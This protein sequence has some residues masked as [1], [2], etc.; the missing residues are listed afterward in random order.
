MT[1]SPPRTERKGPLLFL[2]VAAL[3]LWGYN[4]SLVARGLS[5]SDDDEVVAPPAPVHQ[6]SS[7][8]L[9]G[10]GYP[11]PF[12]PLAFSSPDHTVTW[13]PT[14]S[15][16]DVSPGSTTS[17]TDTTPQ[18]SPATPSYEPSFDWQPEPY[19][20]PPPPLA[21]RGVVGRRALIADME[22]TVHLL[23]PGDTLAGA[24]LQRV[25]DGEAHLT[26]GGSPFTLSL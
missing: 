7:R 1:V 2:T 9:F 19:V 22:G 26:F 14:T 16:A 8:P 20:E 17:G 24:A 4:A 18:S 25:G 12:E 5:A 11:D 10:V 21:L 6:R 15:G 13:D 3:A 23:A